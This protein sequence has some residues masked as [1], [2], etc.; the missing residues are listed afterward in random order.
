MKLIWTVRCLNWDCKWVEEGENLPT[1]L[2]AAR[3]HIDQFGWQDHS[4]ALHNHLEKQ[5]KKQPLR[6]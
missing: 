6:N 1:L 3:R 2:E 4:Y 5:S